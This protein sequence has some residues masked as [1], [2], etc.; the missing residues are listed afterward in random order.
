MYTSNHIYD[1]YND[2]ESLFLGFLKEDL[3]YFFLNMFQ[4][5]LNQIIKLYSNTVQKC[6]IINPLAPKNLK[7]KPS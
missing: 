6:G 5:F 7:Y 2:N 3:F 1:E 4:D